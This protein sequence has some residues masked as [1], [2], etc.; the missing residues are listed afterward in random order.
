MHSQHDVTSYFKTFVSGETE[1]ISTQ[2]LLHIS[3]MRTLPS[4][5]TNVYSPPRAQKTTLDPALTAKYY[6]K[7][8]NKL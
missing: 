5:L 2:G 3:L 8:N 7:I 4:L 1:E 6:T